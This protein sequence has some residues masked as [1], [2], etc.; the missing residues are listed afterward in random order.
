MSQDTGLKNL[1][2]RQMKQVTQFQLNITSIMICATYMPRKL[3]SVTNSLRNEQ[4]I[5]QCEL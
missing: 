1:S 3:N 4:L 2:L 5:I